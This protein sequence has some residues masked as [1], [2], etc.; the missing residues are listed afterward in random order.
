MNNFHVY[1]CVVHQPNSVRRESKHFHKP[2]RT[3]TENNQKFWKG[4]APLGASI[5]K[6]CFSPFT[7]RERNNLKQTETSPSEN[8]V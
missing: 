6:E 3:V 5:C 7:N 4:D 8:M 2:P 1:Q